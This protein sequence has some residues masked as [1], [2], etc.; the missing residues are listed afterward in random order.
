MAERP[1]PDWLLAQ[2]LFAQG[3]SPKVIASQV[4]ASLEAVHKRAQRG[5][6]SVLADKTRSVAVQC[7]EHAV[8]TVLSGYS[9]DTR[10]ALG[11]AITEHVAKIPSAKGWKHANRIQQ[12]LEPLVRNAKTVFG[13]GNDDGSK[14]SVRIGVLN[15]ATVQALPN[16]EPLGLDTKHALTLSPEAPE[17]PSPL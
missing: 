5:Q 3:M 17:S 14:A 2:T 6:W 15:M 12:E 7:A 11:R 13:W 1:A 10:K 16:T 9:L 4:G 8:E